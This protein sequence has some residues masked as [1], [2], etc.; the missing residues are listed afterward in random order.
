V[1]DAEDL[2]KVGKGIVLEQ[3]QELVSDPAMQ[4][5]EHGVGES[6]TV[7][8]AS[9]FAHPTPTPAAPATPVSMHGSDNNGFKHSCS[10]P[11]LPAAP[12]PPAVSTVK[13]PWGQQDEEVSLWFWVPTDTGVISIWGEPV[14]V[15]P[16]T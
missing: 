14:M 6:P 2:H 3:E 1:R 13:D 5:G 12:T 15:G 4:G 7:P 16:T 9:A 11:Q 8:P 10:L